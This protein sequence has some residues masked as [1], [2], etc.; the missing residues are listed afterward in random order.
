MKLT[1]IFFTILISMSSKACYMEAQQYR[2][3]TR[4]REYDESSSKCKKALIEDYSNYLYHPLNLHLRG[5][6]TNEL[7][8]YLLPSFE[9]AYNQLSKAGE[10]KLYRGIKS[11]YRTLNIIQE[12]ECFLEHG[13]LSTS[14]SRNVA[15]KFTPK[16]R[17]IVLE[18]KA[19]SGR[20]FGFF[21]GRF[22]EF[23]VLFAPGS[24][25]KLKKIHHKKAWEKDGTPEKVFE[26]NEVLD[27]S[28]CDVLH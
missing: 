6:E 21:T 16:E 28:S 3:C 23:E 2:E 24:I 17:P 18:F 10:K 27:S 22:F 20:K 13:Y 7:C 26:F 11:E 8:E 9:W 19:F 12:G 25:F 4:S 14:T 15:K 5:I 1:F